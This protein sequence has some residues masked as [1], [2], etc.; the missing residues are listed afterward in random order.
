MIRL[1]RPGGVRALVAENL[2][3][4]QQLLV[5]ARSRHRAPNLS[6][7]ER[8]VLGLCTLHVSP[9]RLPKVAAGLRPSTL[10][11]HHQCLVRRKYR[12]PVLVTAL[13]EK[14]R[15]EGTVR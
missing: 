5:L 15:T 2:I 9:R 3:M 13:R 12:A 7:L 6:R 4:K 8:L 1:V 10:L 11:N 14:P